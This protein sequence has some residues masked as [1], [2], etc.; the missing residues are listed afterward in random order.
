M[1]ILYFGGGFDPI[2]HGHLIS[3]RAVAETLGFDRIVLVPTGQPPHKTVGTEFTSGQ[4][5]LQMCRLATA[6]SPSF[7]VSEIELKLPLPSYTIET[8]REI[9]RRGV[10]PVHWLIGADMLLYLPK[11]HRPADL[12]REVQFVVMARPGW[13]L[14]WQTLPPEFRHLEENVAQAPLINISASDIRR[15]VKAGLPIDFLTPPAVCDH[16]RNRGLYR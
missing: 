12:L 9:T 16:I 11:W 1:P 2:H 8:V 14:D 13:N 10:D 15:R 5:R 3:S 6:G 4:D 7:E